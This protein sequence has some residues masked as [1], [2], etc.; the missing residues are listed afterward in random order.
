M[1][2]DFVASPFGSA[3]F[4]AV[5]TGFVSAVSVCMVRAG[6]DAACPAVS[7]RVV[8]CGAGPPRVSPAWTEQTGQAPG[9]WPLRTFSATAICWSLVARSARGAY[10]VPP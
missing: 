5:A 6:A 9:P 4:E 1:G 8:T 2:A 7:A 3:F 10:A